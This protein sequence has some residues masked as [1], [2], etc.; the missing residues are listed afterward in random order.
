[1]Q[2]GAWEESVEAYRLASLLDPDNARRASGWLYAASLSPTISFEDVVRLHR[3]WGRKIEASTPVETLQPDLSVDRALRIGYVSPDL[4]GHATMQFLYPLLKAHD[5]SA[6]QL[7]MYS[8]T[9]QEDET[10]N[11]VRILGDEWCCTKALSNEQLAAQIQADR[12]D[13]L[14][15]VAGHTADNRLPVF[16]RK[17]APVQVSFLGYPTTT[18]LSRIDYFLTDVI[19]EPGD[20]KSH[21]SEQAV[22][23][24]HGA[25]CFH[26]IDAPDV[27]PPPRLTNGHITL[28]STH[29]PEKIST[30]SLNAWVQILAELPNAR[31][32][33]FRDSLKSDSLRMG[34]TRRLQNAGADLSRI[35]FGWDLPQA[36]LDVYSRFDILLNVFPWGSGTVAYDAMWMGVPIP[37]IAGDR[38]GCRATASMMY[39][40][41]FP[42]LI[43][44]TITDYVALVTNLASDH[45]RLDSLRQEIRPAMSNTVCDGARFAQDIE[46]MLKQFWK[47][48]VESHTT[49]P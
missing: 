4:R 12:V 40:S 30:E 2:I 8:E 43:A 45:D 47:T 31:L 44:D 34:M 46:R 11:V 22:L 36:H 16:A 6:F 28:G 27:A 25:C 32:L 33:I 14:I 13:I 19:R 3:E 21:F 35:D 20:T 24:P 39:N 5:R 41:G 38:G 37:T 10:T 7:V 49:L 9:V 18:G 29:R 15:D 26:A 17:P 42:E 1:M 48:Y 23:L